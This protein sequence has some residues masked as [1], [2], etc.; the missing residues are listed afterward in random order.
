M[1]GQEFSFIYIIYLAMLDLSFCMQYPQS[2]MQ[3]VD[4]YLW[5]AESF[6]SCSMQASSPSMWEPVPWPGTELRSAALGV[7]SL[8]HWTTKEVPRIFLCQHLE[9]KFCMFHVLT[10]IPMWSRV[11]WLNRQYL[12]FKV[13]TTLTFF[14]LL[15]NSFMIPEAKLFYD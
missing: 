3:H 8:S 7:W 14:P 5:H 4:S 13:L 11:R 1:W 2:L 10:Q 9:P 6:F 15:L 12:L